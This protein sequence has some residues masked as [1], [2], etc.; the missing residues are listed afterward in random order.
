MAMIELVVMIQMRIVTSR[1]R[2]G[3]VVG[4]T[5]DMN[6]QG[7]MTVRLVGLRSRQERHDEKERKGKERKE[8][9]RRPEDEREEPQLV[10]STR[11]HVW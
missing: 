9:A 5:A 4:R 6:I 1:A 8:R 3:G 10:H 11:F 7:G 2:R